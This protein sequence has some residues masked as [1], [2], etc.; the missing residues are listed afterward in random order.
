MPKYSVL[1][2]KTLTPR[3]KYTESTADTGSTENTADIIKITA[4]V[5]QDIN[6]RAVFICLKRKSSDKSV[7]E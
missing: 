5:I 4:T 2:L 1:C 7:I 3:Q 6:I